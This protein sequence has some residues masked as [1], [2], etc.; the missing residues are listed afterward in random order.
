[1]VLV[2]WKY[3]KWLKNVNWC[4]WYMRMVLSKDCDDWMPFVWWWMDYI[5]MASG[6]W[7]LI[8]VFTSSLHLK[9]RR[10]RLYWSHVKIWQWIN[11]FLVLFACA[12]CRKQVLPLERL[13][14][15]CVVVLE[16]CCK[17]PSLPHPYLIIAS[18]FSLVQYLRN[19]SV[20]GIKPCI[21]FY[22]YIS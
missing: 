19:K 15:S 22:L 1:M 6:F 3:V 16:G 5:Y 10:N 11:F 21:I 18:L 12:H 7:V 13:Q 4:L 14:D 20:S 2:V 8:F 17:F 9:S